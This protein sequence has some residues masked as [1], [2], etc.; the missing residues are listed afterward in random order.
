M[1]NDK[2]TLKEALDEFDLCVEHETDNRSAALEDIRFALLDEQWPAEIVKQRELEGRPCLTINKTRQFI[3]QVVNNGRRN[4][5]A[6]KV[7]PADSKAD[8]KTAEIISGLI[9]NIEY[10]SNADV[11]Y[12]TGLEFAVAGGFGYWRVTADYADEDSFDMDLGIGRISNP[13]SVYG[14]PY[15]TAADSSDW[16]TAFI[17][18]LLTE[19]L[20]ESKYKGAEKVDWDIGEYAELGENWREGKKIVV[21]E[22]WKRNEVKKK[23]VRLSDGR[24][25]Q[26]DWYHGAAPEAEGLTIKD[27]LDSMGI[28]VT[29]E[30]E[31]KGW[32]VKQQIMSGAEIL[33]ENDW[34]GKYIPIVPIYGEEVNVEGK[35]Y[36][37]SLHRSGKDA[38]RSFNYWRTTT[39]ELVALAPKAP[40]IGPVG[41]FVTDAEKWAT[42]NTT[43]H[44]FLEYDA[45]PEAGNMPPQRQPFSGVPAGPLQEALNASDDMKAIFGMYDA[46]MG[47]RSN[48]TSG[49]A[50]NQRKMQ[51]DMSNFHFIDNQARAIAHTGRI[52]I[53]LI[54]HYYSQA[55]IIR[56]MGLDNK[57]QNV[58]INQ[59]IPGTEQ[60]YNLALGKYDLTVSTGPSFAS[61]REEAAYQMTEFIRA[62]PA[63]APLI[64]DLLAKNQDW[65]EADEIARRLQS[66]LPP[67]VQGQNPQVQQMQQQIQQ[68]SQNMANLG[69]QLQQEKADKA[70][71][72]RKLD[73][74]AYKAESDRLK[75]M[76]GGMTP[77]QVQIMVMQTIQQVL[78]SPDV[79]PMQPMQAM[80][81][82]P[83]GQMMP[84]A[85]MPPQMPQG[86]PPMPPNGPPNP[87]MNQ[88][89]P[90]QGGFFTP[91]ASQ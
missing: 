76:G 50:I 78:Q 61:Q 82:M 80:H 72:A 66:V 5:P 64:G 15:S 14:D 34:L 13:F 55:R 86:A 49:V 40:Y 32:K 91:G 47:A 48:E 44:A 46:S 28:T 52:L 16:N 87:T 22:R 83:N 38:Q 62:F 81:Q 18:D 42:A 60:M 85:A 6:I 25:V 8:P 59:P 1:A 70:L 73:I 79:L 57:P 30:R 90:P 10:T 20:F 89:Q 51:G 3:K 56:V 29:G 2:D 26:A 9:R 33:E 71:E 75:V 84:N 88:P 74:D 31:T 43:S 45:V 23:I 65:P 11:A 58:P 17:T 4:K 35:R 69:Q 36:L 41:A 67:Q 12:D 54:P 68:M 63:A 21:A 77:E 19:E 27:I 24:I 53:D 7:H 37:R 39:T